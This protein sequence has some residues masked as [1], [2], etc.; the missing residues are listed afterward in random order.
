M[1]EKGLIG[2]KI[3]QLRENRADRTRIHDPAKAEEMAYAEKPH[4]ERAIQQR[5]VG[6]ALVKQV[7]ENYPNFDRS[8]VITTEEISTRTNGEISDADIV[9]RTHEGIADLRNRVASRKVTSERG[10]E[11]RQNKVDEL[12]QVNPAAIPNH[13]A[14]RVG[15]ELQDVSARKSTEAADAA[16]EAAGVAYDQAQLLVGAE[17]NAQPGEGTTR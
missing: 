6:K 1:T 12:T 2:K 14:Q 11:R 16:A 13:L 5:K 15:Y 17:K 10:Y 3:D 9:A 7:W 4:R 8:K